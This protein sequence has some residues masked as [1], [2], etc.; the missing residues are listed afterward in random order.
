MPDGYNLL[1][2]DLRFILRVTTTLRDSITQAVVAVCC[3]SG[4]WAAAPPEHPYAGAQACAQCHEAKFLQQSQTGHANSLHR[5]AEHPLAPSFITSEPLRREPGYEFIFF[6]T[7]EG[8]RVRAAGKDDVMEMNLDW[9]FGAG[10]QGVT[11]VTRGNAQWYLEHAFS[12]FTGPGSFAHTPGHEGPADSLPKAVGILYEIADAGSGILQCFDCHSTGPVALG[13]GRV[14][15]PLEP[16]VQCESCHGPGRLHIE[17]MRSGNLKRGLDLIRNLGRL[18][19]VEL[20]EQCGACH[21]ST[22]L[23]APVDWEDPWNTRH[24]PVYLVQSRCFQRSAGRLSCLT[25]HDPHGEL[26]RSEPA[27]YAEKCSRCHEGV[28]HPNEG[29][30]KTEAADCSGCHMPK[31]QPHPHLKFTNHWVGVFRADKPLRPVR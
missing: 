11:F 10:E 22:E 27:Y 25:C 4:L 28:R 16:G 30:A 1:E 26:R 17:A 5:A 19:A 23:G 24:A 21:R 3:V 18:S 31:V 2:I 13:A 14:I 6:R 8:P 9:A 15:H 29:F 12:Y 20:V 7:S